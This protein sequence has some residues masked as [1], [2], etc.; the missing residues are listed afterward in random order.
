M[1]KRMRKVSIQC[2]ALICSLL[3]AGS[4][5]AA[6]GPGTVVGNGGGLSEQNFNFAFASLERLYEICAASLPSCLN[7]KHERDVFEMIRKA[8]PLERKAGLALNFIS[9][10]A[11]PER[12]RIDG[13]MRL[14]VTNSRVG[15]VIDVN[16]D[17]LYAMNAEGH[18]Q[19][20]VDVGT[21]VSILTHE[22]GHHQGI[23]DHQLLDLIGA[24][25]RVFAMT[26]A[27]ILKVDTYGDTYDMQIP[28]T[29]AVYAFH[30]NVVPDDDMQGSQS[31]LGLSDGV[32]FYE[33]NSLVEKNLK[34]PVAGGAEQSVIG[35]RFYKMRWTTRDDSRAGW[36][37]YQ[38]R[39]SAFLVC[40][41]RGPR[42][43][44]EFDIVFDIAFALQ[45]SPSG[46]KWVMQPKEFRA[47]VIRR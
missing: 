12:F 13:Q 31:R 3:F 15:D 14:A 39:S 44:N 43:D 11:H 9:G 29:V 47:K 24:K 34:C 38:M 40:D 26:E 25:V 32:G 2:K 18:V 7:D 16:T 36:R 46:M 21:A 28:A 1:R 30:S 4:A 33:L 22:L 8:L 45:N 5:F 6:K 42:G 17:M 23:L 35:Y 41:D 27:D 37:T 20:V 19:S 10:T